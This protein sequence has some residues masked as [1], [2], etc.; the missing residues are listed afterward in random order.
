MSTFHQSHYY[1]THPGRMAT[2]GG[3]TYNLRFASDKIS[4]IYFSSQR[5]GCVLYLHVLL[6]TI[7]V[8][9]FFKAFS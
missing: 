7:D 4:I 2:F 5:P 8:E 1:L 3:Q 9:L 6:F